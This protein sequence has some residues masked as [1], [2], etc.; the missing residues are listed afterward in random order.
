MNKTAVVLSTVGIS[1][2]LGLSGC[3]SN[4]N[5]PSTSSP[6]PSGS[7]VGTVLPPIMITKAESITVK[8]GDYLNVTTPNVTKVSTDNASV[9]DIS[10]PHSDGSAQFNG[11]AKVVGPGKANLV[12][13]GGIT[14]LELYSVSV[15]ATG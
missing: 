15:T 11:G 14:N 7:G 4:A 2:A 13:Y 12:V 10:Q 1:L 6:S 3:S 9:L 5:S 8:V